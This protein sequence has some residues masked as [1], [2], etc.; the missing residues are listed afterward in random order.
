MDGIDLLPLLLQAG[1]AN[2]GAVPGEV[3]TLPSGVARGADGVIDGLRTGREV[4]FTE[5]LTAEGARGMKPWRGVWTTNESPIGRWVYTA[6]VTGEQ[7]LYDV[8]GGPC[9]TWRPGRA[10]GPVSARP[11]SPA[12]PT[13]RRSAASWPTPW[14]G[15]AV[16]RSISSST[17]QGDCVRNHH[18]VDWSS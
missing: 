16:T 15:A 3:R 7:E 12:T 5:H 9:W 2:R 1:E 14:P 11:T 8:S 18:G 17:P 10:G 13:T 6:Y 4:I